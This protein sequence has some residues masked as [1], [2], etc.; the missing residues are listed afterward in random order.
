MQTFLVYLRAAMPRVPALLAGL[1]LFGVGIALQVRSGLGLAP[2]EVMH[3][4]I[5]F[6]TPLTIGVAGILT[7]VLVL[8]LWIPL[9]QKPGIGTI[10]NVI[11]IGLSIDATLLILDDVATTLLQWVYMLGGIV[12]VGLGSGIYIGVRL[13]PGPRD[14]LMTGLAERGL[15]VRVARLGIEGSVL[16]IGWLLGGTIGIGTVAF[17]VLIGPIVQFFLERLDQGELELEPL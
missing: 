4:G 12:I 8:L 17:T 6:H 11:V 10:T 5:S 1:V 7:G 16:V 15:S 14:G 13:G 2:W 3:Q 9:K